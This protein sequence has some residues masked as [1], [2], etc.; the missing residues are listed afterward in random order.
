MEPARPLLEELFRQFREK[1]PSLVRELR[2]FEQRL[3]KRGLREQS[4]V[5]RDQRLLGPSD[6][7]VGQEEEG[8][9]S[10]RPRAH[11]L[12]E[13]ERVVD[14]M[15]ENGDLGLLRFTPPQEVR[16]PVGGRRLQ[17]RKRICGNLG[18]RIFHDGEQRAQGRI[19]VERKKSP[20]RKL[21]DF[22]GRGAAPQ[23]GNEIFG[24]GGVLQVSPDYSRSPWR[25]ERPR[26]PDGLPARGQIREDDVPHD[27]PRTAEG[28][29]RPSVD[30][31]PDSPGVSE[32]DAESFPRLERSTHSGRNRSSEDLL[33]IRRDLDPRR[34]VELQNDATPFGT[35]AGIT[36][37]GESSRMSGVGSLDGATFLNETG[38]IREATDGR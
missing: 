2:V 27:L 33:S 13:D 37:S 30:R 23:Q 29:Q 10:S 38:S 8:A 17:S 22:P 11:D 26:R 7:G 12:L 25:R 35:A 28:R 9:V 3:D 20:G 18:V 4:R 24:G 31:Y 36:G 21:P 16:Q 32:G 34:F 15:G 14:A 5:V 1:T 6:R 19:G